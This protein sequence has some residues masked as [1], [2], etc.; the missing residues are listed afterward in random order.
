M[1]NLND[2]GVV[3]ARIQTVEQIYQLVW[4]AVENKWT[5]EAF[6]DGRS[7]LFF[8]HRWAGIGKGS[9]VSFAISMAGTARVD[10]NPRAHLLT[11]AALRWKS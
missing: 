1:V 4:T 8:P 6:Y 2:M 3:E 5:I 7:R 11:G 10:C 9:F